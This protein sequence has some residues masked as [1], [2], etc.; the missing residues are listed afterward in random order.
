MATSDV[1]SVRS[2]RHCRLGFSMRLRTYSTFLS[3]DSEPTQN[4]GAIG[5][6]SGLSGFRVPRYGAVSDFR[7]RTEQNKTNSDFSQK[8]KEN[9][10]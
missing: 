2:V 3:S 9:C 6:L 5:Y 10:G 7:L 8:V 4:L 1:G